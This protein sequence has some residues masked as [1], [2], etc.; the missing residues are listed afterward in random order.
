MRKGWIWLLVAV[1]AMG[2]GFSACSKSDDTEQPKATL[3]EVTEKTKEAIQKN[4]NAPI[5]KAR[6]IQNLGEERLKAVDEAL[7]K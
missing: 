2:I 1:M 4:M 7:K 6:T 5:E 3:K